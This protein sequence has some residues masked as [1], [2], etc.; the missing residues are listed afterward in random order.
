MEYR[1]Q[2]FRRCQSV[3]LFSPT[4]DHAIEREGDCLSF[5][6]GTIEYRFVIQPTFVMHFNFVV[7]VGL[8]PPVLRRIR[9]FKPDAVSLNSRGES[10]SIAQALPSP[11]FFRPAVIGDWLSSTLP[12]TAL[13]QLERLEPRPLGENTLRTGCHG[14]KQQKRKLSES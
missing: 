8:R 3:E 13:L 12:F 10:A 9:Y 6:I 14:S 4:L 11:G 5:A 1:V 7:A 2:S